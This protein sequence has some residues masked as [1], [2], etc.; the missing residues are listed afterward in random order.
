MQLEL[1]NGQWGYRRRIRIAGRTVTVTAIENP[2]GNW[3]GYVGGRR[4]D[5]AFFG[6]QQDDAAAWVANYPNVEER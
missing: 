1:I 4:V 2:W 5:G 6:L 3:R